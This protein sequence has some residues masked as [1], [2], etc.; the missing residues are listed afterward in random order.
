MVLSWKKKRKM[1]SQTFQNFSPKRD[2][3]KS[4][5]SWV[6]QPTKS[7]GQPNPLDSRE[8]ERRIGQNSLLSSWRQG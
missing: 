4:E 1:A 3:S 5:I 7:L 6:I 2:N 8:R